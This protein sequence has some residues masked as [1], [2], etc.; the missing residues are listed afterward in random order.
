MQHEDFIWFLTDSQEDEVLPLLSCPDCAEELGCL[1]L[2]AFVR[3][4]GEVVYWDR[5]GR[6]IHEEDEW[7]KLAQ[8]GF[9]CKEVMSEEDCRIYGD[10]TPV[11]G[12]DDWWVSEHWREELFQR[13]KNYLRKHYKSTKGVKWLKEVNWKFSADNYWEIVNFYREIPSDM[14]E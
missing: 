12:I 1:L 13:D 10:D 11:A 4:D 5:I 3:K 9:T 6:I 14:E 7:E 8:N 2:C